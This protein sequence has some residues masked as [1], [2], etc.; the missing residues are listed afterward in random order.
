MKI[1]GSDFW[2]FAK[3]IIGL[4]KLITEIFGDA[5]DKDQIQNHLSE[6][7]THGTR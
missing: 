2:L 3:L 6:G 5:E 7:D 1:F 4:I